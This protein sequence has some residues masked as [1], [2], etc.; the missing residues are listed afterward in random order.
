MFQEY[1][2]GVVKHDMSPLL[3]LFSVETKNGLLR[4]KC[5]HKNEIIKFFLDDQTVCVIREPQ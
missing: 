5:M 2:S 1:F 3:W 4:V